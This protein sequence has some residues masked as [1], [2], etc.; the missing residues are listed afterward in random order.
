MGYNEGI[1]LTLLFIFLSSQAGAFTLADLKTGD[2]LLQSAAC[3]LCSKIEAEESSPYSHVGIVLIEKTQVFVLDSWARVE[4]LPIRKFLA[5]RRPGTHTQV[6]RLIDGTGKELKLD[7]Q[8][9]STV[10][11]QNFKDLNY[12]DTFLWDNQDAKGEKLYCSEFVAKFLNRFI[13]VP[14]S[15]KPMHYTHD[16]AAWINYFHGTPPDGKPGISPGDFEKS[17][18]LKAVGDLW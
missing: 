14:F 1:M 9:F 6:S 3:A 13:P 11:D 18:L 10:F 15:P 16:R 8:K 17:P 7:S 4:K 5:H 2:V 12:D